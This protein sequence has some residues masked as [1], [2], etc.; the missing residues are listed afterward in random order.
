[1]KNYIYLFII[2][3]LVLVNIS[4][5][6]IEHPVV[7][8]TN[9]LDWSLFPGGDSSTYA[10]PT[11][12]E[13]TYNQQ[14]VLL[15]DYTG[16]TCTN[17]PAAAVIAKGLE[18]ANPNRV[19][20]ASIHASVGNSFQAVSPPEFTQ[21][22][23]T[24]AGDT[25]VN[26]I[27]SFF[28]N[29]TGTI[30]RKDGGIANTIWYASS[31]WAGAVNTTLNETPNAKIQQQYNYFPQT[32]GL[33]V[34]TESV[35]NTLNNNNEY[36]MVIYLVREVVVAPQKLANGTVEEFYHHHNVLTDNLNGTWGITLE[37]T[38][39]KQYHNLA[40]QLPDNSSDTTYNINNLSLIS[41]IYNKTNYKVEQ[42][43]KT[44][45]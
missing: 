26:S 38:T 24:E 11:W 10:W 35:L 45:L 17:C 6:K 19:F 37:N 9:E 39:D 44:E 42:V 40:I 29:P 23:T 14:N 7:E 43:I 16:H 5:D 1:M 30:N 18:D 33:F 21:D 41:Y 36:A 25:Y 4:C 28:G 15:E 32:R 31:N 12:T 22:F 8:H 13:N 2:T 34:H 3:T 20:V 27:P